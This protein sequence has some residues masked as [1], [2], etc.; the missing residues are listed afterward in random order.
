MTEN[1]EERIRT[2]FAA[3]EPIYKR[4]G[5]VILTDAR[6]LHDVVGHVIRAWRRDAVDFVRDFKDAVHQQNGI[7][8]RD[9]LDDPVNV[10]GVLFCRA[11]HKVSL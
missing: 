2:L 7:A 1:P 8:V 10:D 11:V 4:S 9:H 6:S 5:T 3:R